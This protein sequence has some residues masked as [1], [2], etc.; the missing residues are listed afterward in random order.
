[1]ESTGQ[2]M[3][4]RAVSTTSFKVTFVAMKIQITQ[5]TRDLLESFGEFHF[6]Q[7]GVMQIKGKGE[8]NTYWL[9]EE[10]CGLNV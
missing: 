1:M 2:G 7:R 4:L 3:Y 9:L 8:M 6:Q 5:A 10:M